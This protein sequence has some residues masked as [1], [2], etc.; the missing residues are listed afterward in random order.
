M[1][2]LGSQ[3]LLTV[4]LAALGAC[5]DPADPPD[6]ADP[7]DSGTRDGGAPDAGAADYE[8]TVVTFNSGTTMGLPHDDPPDDGYGS[9]QALVS[10]TYYGDG[11]AWQAAVDAARAFFAEVDPDVVVFQEIFFSDECAMIP[12]DARTGFVCET[13]SP[14][15]PTVAQVVLGPD[16]QLACNLDKPDKCAAVHRRVGTFRGCAADLCLDGLDGARVPD[17]GGG[18][19]V[20]RG[21]IDL[22]GGGEL[23]LVLVHG[24]SGITAE[25]QQCRVRQFEQVF[26]DLDGAAA[27]SGAANL[28]MGDLNTDPYR[29][30]DGDPSAAR[31]LDFVGQ[32]G[33]GRPFHFLTDAGRRAEPTYADLFNIDHVASDHFDG[34]CWAAGIDGRDPVWEGVY[35]DHLPIVCN[36]YGAQ[37]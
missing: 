30:A 26:V 9:E 14:G 34:D 8:L 31:F 5:S 29:F 3:A 17:C 37:P 28:V 27:A 22:V 36:A 6:D 19:R 16:Y 4:A 24:T 20:G 35:F 25:E 12:A 13:W 10:D 15:D 23:T 1:R 7:P 33:E 21:V 18:S 32:P 2:R 11:L